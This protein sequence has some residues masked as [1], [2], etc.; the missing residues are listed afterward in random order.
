M[1]KQNLITAA[2]AVA[3]AAALGLGG[4]ALA[5]AGQ[6]APA[7]V[8]ADASPTANPGNSN[9]NGNGNANGNGNGNRM[10]PPGQPK[11][12]L[13][14][15]VTEHG[16]TGETAVKVTQAAVT[17]EPTAYLLRVGKAEDGTYR[18]R[19]MRPDGTMIVVKIDANFAVTSVD[20]APDKV[21]P[22]PHKP[23]NGA[24]STASP[25]AT[26]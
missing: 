25:S 5:Q 22:G 9:G 4:A 3:T 2:A 1:K 26:S 12:K 21:R 18:A 7:G 6:S 8:Q 11:E 10:R 16:I 17:K 24:T 23:G 14:E 20:N 19:M 15:F 13:K